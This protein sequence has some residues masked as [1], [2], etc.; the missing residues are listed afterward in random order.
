[1]DRRI[2][3]DPIQALP[4]LQRDMYN[5]IEAVGQ[6]VRLGT[7][8]VG[9]GRFDGCSDVNITSLLLMLAT[10]HTGAH[11]VETALTIVCYIVEKELIPISML[12]AQQ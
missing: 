1:M 5:V 7:G 11:V 6:N 12:F 10:V 2:A 8:H 4:L 9:L 3:D